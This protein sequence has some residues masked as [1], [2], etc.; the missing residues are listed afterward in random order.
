L[1]HGVSKYRNAGIFVLIYVMIVYYSRHSKTGMVAMLRN[2]TIEESG[3]DAGQRKG[4]ELYIPV[5][6]GYF[7]ACTRFSFPQRKVIGLTS[8][9]HL[10]Y[11]RKGGSVLST[12]HAIRLHGLVLNQVQGRF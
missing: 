3:F 11:F 4:T 2:W 8:H 6:P 9:I 1:L 10:M 12:P 5:N 7:S